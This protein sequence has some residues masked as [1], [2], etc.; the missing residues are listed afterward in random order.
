MI[1]LL[2]PVVVVV[3][4]TIVAVVVAIVV[5]VAVALVV[6]VLVLVVVVVVTYYPATS[7]L[8]VF[9]MSSNDA[10]CAYRCVCRVLHKARPPAQQ[11]CRCQ[12]QE[13]PCMFPAVSI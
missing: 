11:L 4:L 8:L 7:R 13:T 10:Y 2:A 1:G 12:R 6:L 5:V 9:S 3:V